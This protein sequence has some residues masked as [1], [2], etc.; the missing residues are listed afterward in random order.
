MLEKTSPYKAITQ[1]TFKNAVIRLLENEYK[2]IG[3]HKVIK[4]IAEDIEDLRRSFYP[5]VANFG[6]GTL[7]WT[8]TSRDAK[9]GKVG[10]KSCEYPMVTIALPYITDEDVKERTRD[11]SSKAKGRHES[12]QAE[13]KRLVRIIKEAYRR[14]GLLTIAELSI[15]MNRS[16]NIISGYLREYRREHP[17]EM[18]P[19]RGHIL[20]QGS[21]PS[22]KGEIVNLYESKVSPPDIARITGH[23]QEAV[24]H[25]IKDYERV[26]LL[27]K[28]AQSRTEISCLTGRGQRVVDKYIQ[29]AYKHHPELRKM[30]R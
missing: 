30:L 22:H 13:I 9:K 12:R 25:Y 2:L 16:T 4:M 8:T 29:M 7:I 5:D 20:D 19:L 24:D 28:K 17:D 14:G 6:K 21:S 27:L 10:K 15:I 11:Y 18:L 23:G 1:K 3:S 26:K